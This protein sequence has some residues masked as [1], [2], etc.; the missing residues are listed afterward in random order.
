MPKRSSKDP[1]VTAF[2]IV[3]QATEEPRDESAMTQALSND[4][5]RRQ[6]MREM[7]RRGGQKGGKARAAKLSKRARSEIAREAA[8]MRWSG[9]KRAANK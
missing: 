6:I 9:K 2:S 7:G 8:N 5:L 3:Q 4:E 1:N